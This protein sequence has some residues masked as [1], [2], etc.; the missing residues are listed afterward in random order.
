MV[1]MNHSIELSINILFRKEE[2]RINQIDWKII[3]DFNILIKTAIYIL[4]V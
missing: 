2:K 1:P 4:L 3:Y